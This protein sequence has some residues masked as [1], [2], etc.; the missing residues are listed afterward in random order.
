MG[1][2]RASEFP[3]SRQRFRNENPR[4]LGR[5][6]RKW[7]E[8]RRAAEGGEK[9]KNSGYWGGPGLGTPP[10]K[11]LEVEASLGRS[12]TGLLSAWKGAGG[13]G[14]LG[15]LTEGVGRTEESGQSPPQGAEIGA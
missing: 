4:D 1:R 9:R 14:P 6:S 10:P 2:P 7:G 15:I 3:L 5:L 13:R 11:C 12:P 8:V